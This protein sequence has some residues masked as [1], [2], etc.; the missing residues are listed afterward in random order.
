M[1]VH[2]VHEH[3]YEHELPQS[4]C[5]G[6]KVGKLFS[7]FDIYVLRWSYFCWIRALCLLIQHKD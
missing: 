5:D 6:N 2:H 7:W 1:Y 4:H 3:E